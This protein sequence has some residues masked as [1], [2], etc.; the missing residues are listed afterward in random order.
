MPKEIKKTETRYFNVNDCADY[1]CVS[2]QFA[3]KFCK[4]IGAERRIGKRY[5]YDKQ[6]ID[7]YL[8]SQ[9]GGNVEA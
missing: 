6:T 4:E 8:E 1:L 5:I 9:K 3:R 7:S 2:P